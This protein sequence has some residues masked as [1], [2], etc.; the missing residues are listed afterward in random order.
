MYQSMCMYMYIHICGMVTDAV[1]FSQC[2]RC[3]WNIKRW[4]ESTEKRGWTKEQE[5]SSIKLAQRLDA[6]SYSAVSESYSAV[7]TL[8]WHAVPVWHCQSNGSRSNRM[9]R[10]N[11]RSELNITATTFCSCWCGET[12]E[13]TGWRQ[14]YG[15]GCMEG[16]PPSSEHSSY[17]V[18]WSHYCY[19]SPASSNPV[20]IGNSHTEQEQAW[21]G[22]HLLKLASSFLTQFAISFILKT[23][24]PS[25]RSARSTYSK[26]V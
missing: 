24:A 12:E 23:N 17:W 19:H 6:E 5:P 15:Q 2:Y 25:Q 1:L 9:T 21:H 7:S 4:W 22:A 3:E 11:R 14:N 26:S 13:V 8:P 18:P 16:W 20:N 10:S